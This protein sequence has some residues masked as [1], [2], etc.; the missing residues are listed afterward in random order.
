MRKFNK[1]LWVSAVLASVSTG[2]LPSPAAAQFFF[3]IPIPRFGGNPDSINAT[4]EQRKLAMCAAFH[5]EV[6]DS[7]MNGKRADSWHG[8][9]TQIVMQRLKTFPE[10]KKLVGAYMGQWARQQKQNYESGQA[11][12]RVMM[13]GCGSANL[14]VHKMQYDYWK[15]LTP[16]STGQ[17]ASLDHIPPR[18]VK[19]DGLI[20]ASDFP[21]GFHATKPMYLTTVSL[22]IDAKGTVV[23]CFVEESSGAEE[24]DDATCNL[25]KA[26]A[27]FLPAFEDGRLYPSQYR[28]QQTWKPS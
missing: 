14:P 9:I 21:A 12:A 19:L 2:A 13:E 5:Q 18:P 20:G 22:Q 23:D 7:D 3:L 1:A 4:S 6:V 26:R 27:E 15:T 25:L 10:A 11:Y 17:T 16:D 24:I 28:Y 8:E